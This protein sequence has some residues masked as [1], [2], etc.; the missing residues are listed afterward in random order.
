M[1]LIPKTAPQWNRSL[2]CGLLFGCV[3]LWFFVLTQGGGFASGRAWREAATPVCRGLMP[4]L[5]VALGLSCLYGDGLDNRFRRMAG[6][7]AGLS[8]LLA[9]MLAPALAH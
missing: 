6:L 3:V 1:P 8:I 9:P 7:A 2:A 5:G 4:V